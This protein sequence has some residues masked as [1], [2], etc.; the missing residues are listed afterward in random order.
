MRDKLQGLLLAYLTENNPELLE[1]LEEDDALHAWV[2][3]KLKE[4]ELVLQSSKPLFEIEREAMDIMTADIR[5]SRYR[6]LRDLFEERFPEEY[7]RM[8]DAGTLRYEL[9]TI[10]GICHN[11][12]ESHTIMESIDNP[13]LDRLAVAVISDYLH[14]S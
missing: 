6:Y 11:L 4:V 13:Q 7:D 2:L 3:E 14:N 12:F 5:P 1:Q 8:L 9:V 10:V